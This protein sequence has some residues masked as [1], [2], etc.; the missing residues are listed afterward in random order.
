MFQQAAAQVV[1][2]RVSGL[3]LDYYNLEGDQQKIRRDK[4]NQNHMIDRSLLHIR[5]EAVMF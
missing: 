2:E 5:R 4:W 1:G 3:L